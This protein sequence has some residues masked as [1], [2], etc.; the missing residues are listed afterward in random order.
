MSD[1]KR[2]LDADSDATSD[3][4]SLLR[5]AGDPEP[6][7]E[8]HG[9]VWAALATR[10]PPGGGGGGAPGAGGG[11]AGAKGLSLLA[12][13]LLVSAIAATV[14][15]G[16][17]LAW[18]SAAKPAPKAAATVVTS[19]PPEPT[20][21]AIAQTPPTATVAEIAPTAAPIA[22]A[23]RPH[24]PDAKRPTASAPAIPTH[25]T[26]S[27]PPAPAAPAP[28]P[29]AVDPPAPTT[30]V[31]AL[32][33][34]RALL[35]SARDALR[36]GDGRGALAILQTAQSR[37]PNG[38]LGQEREVLAIE[39]LAQTGD[40]DSASKR[41]SAFLKAFPNSPHAGHVREFVR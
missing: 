11:A 14:G 3:E 27:E 30:A 8:A 21:T 22:P 1:P 13:A 36:K 5:G 32:R 7:K 28:S 2:W 41:A 18:R 37:H 26:T 35:A 16:G 31:D 38:V 17:Y 15:T 4:R 10:L 19:T 12:K 34:E 39:A 33:D 6:P 24:K 25:A 20:G 23:P 29:T 40:R 9:A